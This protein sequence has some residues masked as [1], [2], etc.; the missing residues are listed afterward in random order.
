MSTRVN[1]KLAVPVTGL[2]V[3]LALAGLALGDF[4]ETAYSSLL[5]NLGVAVALI[6][7][8]V[9]LQPALTRVV[10][11][12]AEG[13]AVEAAERSTREIRERVERLEDLEQAQIAER[14]RRH[15]E[16]RTSAERLFEEVLSPSAVGEVLAAAHDV[17]L[18]DGRHFHVRTSSRPD[19]HVL[20]MLPLRA[21]NGIRI[22]WVDFE[23]IQDGDVVDPALGIALPVKGDATV[24]WINDE[25]PS[26]IA[27]ELEAG[28]ERLN[29]P[30]RDFSLAYALERLV[31]SARVMRAARA[32]P[33][34]SPLRMKGELRVLINQR[35]AFTSYG[36]EAVGGPAAFNARTAGLRGG[37]PAAIWWNGC[38][39]G[40]ERPEDEPEDEWS[41]AIRWLE[42]REGLEIL[43]PGERQA[44][45]MA[46]L[47][48]RSSNEP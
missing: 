27:G 18:F 11:H 33:D 39:E 25:P 8:A 28:L 43:R 13:A 2:G 46:R 10:E 20:Y 31:D 45:P 16:G 12:A 30:L 22:M 5:L 3:G 40:C 21:E 14:E 44:H 24:M 41:E 6:A 48:G 26:G 37:P 36:L 42:N 17:R 47:R 15:Q 19:A 9:I 7:L 29:L 32:A 34:G 4:Q 23:P 38:V 1:W 35:W